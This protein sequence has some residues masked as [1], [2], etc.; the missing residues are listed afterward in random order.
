MAQSG[1]SGAVPMNRTETAQI[2]RLRVADALRINADNITV[3]WLDEDRPKVRIPVRL[4]NVETDWPTIEA[5]VAEVMES[6][7]PE[8]VRSMSDTDYAARMRARRKK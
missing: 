6:Y 4:E 3:H 7:E 8:P 5:I 2:I 1:Q